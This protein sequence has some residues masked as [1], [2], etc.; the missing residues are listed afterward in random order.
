MAKYKK[1]KLAKLAAEQSS[2]KLFGDVAKAVIAH[3]VSPT[4][5]MYQG[6]PYR[7]LT[8]CDVSDVPSYLAKFQ[9]QGDIVSGR[10]KPSHVFTTEQLE[11][12][13]MAGI[14]CYP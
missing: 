8:N 7:W 13:N 10:P 11:Q 6:K 4:V 3:Y 5:M 9:K 14:Y 1:E 2:T 12:M